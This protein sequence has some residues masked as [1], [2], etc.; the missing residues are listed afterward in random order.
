M[1][2]EP[3]YKHQQEYKQHSAAH[4]K[5]SA[6]HPN[7]TGHQQDQKEPRVRVHR[8]SPSGKLLDSRLRHSNTAA[9][10]RK[11]P[12]NSLK[13]F[14]ERRIAILL[15]KYPPKKSPSAQITPALKSTCPFLQYI[16]SAPRPSGGN[17]M[18]KDVP[19]DICWP[20]CNR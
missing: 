15:P 14:E 7:A 11:T 2:F 5:Q 17:C 1:L 9:T 4:A 13:S 10:I 20:I 18:N 12:N 8:A 6:R 3:K 16:S 19:C